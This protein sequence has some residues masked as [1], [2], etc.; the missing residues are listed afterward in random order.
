MQSDI[1]LEAL[2]RALFEASL[3]AL[4]AQPEQ[5]QQQQDVVLPA[6]WCK[7]LVR[8]L[9]SFSRKSLA[10]TCHAGFELVM[11]ATPRACLHLECPSY[12]SDYA[13]QRQLVAARRA[14]R[15][16][17]GLGPTAIMVC[18]SPLCAHQH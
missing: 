14:L 12:L 15:V 7:Q 2:V 17:R 4:D 6:A 13:W 8:V 5:E 9:D 3:P 1:D 16:R 11:R 10:L 18:A